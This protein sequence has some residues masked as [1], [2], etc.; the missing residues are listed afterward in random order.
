M[1]KRLSKS[2]LGFTIDE[3]ISA[4]T[5]KYPAGKFPAGY[6]CGPKQSASV[7]YKKCS[8]VKHINLP[9]RHHNKTKKKGS[10]KLPPHA[11]HMPA[12]AQKKK[13]PILCGGMIIAIKS[14]RTQPHRSI[15]K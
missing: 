14:G 15:S 13:Y 12:L 8:V 10:S 2:C 11:R 4:Q 6:F 9:A 3:A 5:N 1:W 7:V